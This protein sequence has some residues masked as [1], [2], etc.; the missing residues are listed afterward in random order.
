M[1]AFTARKVSDN[2]YWVGA[3]DWSLRDFH[4]YKTTRGSTY[5]AYLIMGKEPVLIDTV[6][7]PF[8]NEMMERIRSVIE[9]E[10]IQYIISNH[11]EMDHS[12]CLERA[13]EV[14]QP[15]EVFAS[16]MGI[17]ALREH[18]HFDQP[19]T[20]IKSGE[21]FMLG[22]AKLIAIETRMLHW[23]DSMFTFYA[24]DGVLF[25][26][27]G[28]GMH[29]A[30]TKLFVDENDPDIVH[31][32]AAK[33]YANILL[34]YSSFTKRLLES[35]PKLNLDIKYIAP[36]H[37]PI[38]RRPED[39]Q[40]IMEKW[41]EW[42]DQ[43]FYNKAVIIYDTMW[44]STAAMANSIAEGIA[45]QGTTVKVMPMAGSHRS[46]IITEILDA[47]ALLIG[48]PTINNQMFPSIAEV[49]CYIKGLK[50][51]NLIG[52]AFGSF[53]WSG[54]AVKLVQ[55]ELQNMHVDLTGEPI[56]IKY[57]PENS[58]LAKCREL[59]ATIATELAKK[60]S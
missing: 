16:K 36:D 8:F 43:R 46:E 14:I 4:G 33:Y 12:G 44:G 52:Q 42:A 10:K 20:A 53:G 15:K 41:Q 24:N 22:D 29:L 7:A 21:E 60:L 17:S 48:S 40:F 2:V 39:I 58:D 5:N 38:W 13:I 57:V 35:L 37:G 30:T 50:P 45:E 56:N 49:L 54:E 59:G 11:A 3:I 6:K 32:E 47:G 9:P 1:T 25:S 26:Q 18:F 51:L 19:I 34:V 23:P 55:D 27:D 31:Y 28:F